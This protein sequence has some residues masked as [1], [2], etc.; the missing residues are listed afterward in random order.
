[1]LTAGDAAFPFVRAREEVGD[2]AHAVGSQYWGADSSGYCGRHLP[3][4][5]LA[6]SDRTKVAD[7]VLFVVEVDVMV[8]EVDM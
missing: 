4:S 7:D 8:V 3:W 5:F 2:S 1:V 6:S